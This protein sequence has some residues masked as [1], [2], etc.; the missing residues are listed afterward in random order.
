MRR[1]R[2]MILA[3]LLVVLLVFI[4]SDRVLPVTQRLVG[5]EVEA[6]I[7]DFYDRQD[8]HIAQLGVSIFEDLGDGYWIRVLVS[9]YEDH[10]LERAAAHIFLP[11]ELI[12]HLGLRPYGT[13]EMP[14]AYYRTDQGVRLE[15]YPERYRGTLTN[16]LYLVVRE[17]EREYLPEEITVEMTFELVPRWFGITRYTG[18]TLMEVQIPQE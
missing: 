3:F 4:F 17:T 10:Y 12:G 14:V 18:R 13:H 6:G 15:V 2:K 7:V 5:Q 9:Q 16:Q 8:R 1:L 11:L